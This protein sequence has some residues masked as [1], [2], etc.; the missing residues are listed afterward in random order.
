MHKAGT[1]WLAGLVTLG[2]VACDDGAIDRTDNAVRCRMVCG[3]VKQCLDQS[4]NDE[5]ACRDECKDRALEDSFESKLHDC[6]MCLDN[7][8][9]CLENATDCVDECASV[10][11]LSAS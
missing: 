4:D 10:V 11:A 6:Q 9:S 2:A 5:Q 7:D 8:N 3:H 1:S